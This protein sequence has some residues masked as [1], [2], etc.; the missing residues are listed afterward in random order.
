MQKT[1]RVEWAKDVFRSWHSGG[2]NDSDRIEALKIF[3]ESIS[4]SAYMKR[5][6]ILVAFEWLIDNTVNKEEQGDD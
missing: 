2:W 4:L 3:R 6:D 1:V 5:A